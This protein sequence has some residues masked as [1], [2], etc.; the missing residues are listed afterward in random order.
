MTTV[1]E[2]EA[3]AGA[4][5][6]RKSAGPGTRVTLLTGGG[7]KSYA[8]GLTE[9]LAAQGIG[10]DFIGSDDLDCPE[11]RRQPE[12]KFLNFRGDQRK[13]ASFSSKVLRILKLYL[14]L[15]G[16]APRARPRV[17]HILWNNKF[18]VFDR[19]VLT[20]YYRL[21]GKR[22]VFTAHN[23]NAG[24]RD[25]NDSF[26]NRVSLRCQYFLSDR[27]FVH[28]ERMKREMLTEFH[29]PESK[30]IIIPFGINNT[31]PT[32]ALTCAEAR[33]ALGLSDTDKAMLF[34]GRIAPYKGLEFLISALRL[35]VEKDPSYR[36]VIAGTVK[37]CAEY[38]ATIQQTIAE[39]RLHD[40]I[41]QRIEFIPDSKVE[42][43]FKGCDVVV[44]PYT[45]IFQS[46]VLSLGYSFGLPVVATD[47][48]ALKD[49]IVEGKTGF[50][51]EPRNPAALAA[52]ITAYFTSD[53]YRELPR[54]R[55]E[56]CEY[57]NE[58]YSW[59]KV[60][61][62]TSRVYSELVPGDQA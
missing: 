24:K 40:K 55:Q 58:H 8:I 61:E 49:D 18:Q 5:S 31:S 9:A 47:V 32:T 2:R 6:K 3:S 35:L 28:T 62:I 26:L 15:L 57:A 48:G 46:G 34:F 13:E 20:L 21:L 23:V 41:S 29:V 27:I 45:G 25:G 19:T 4:P 12:V 38:W 44:L 59:T 50:I 60:G 39:G 52:A 42:L 36:V 30:V 43:F 7:D 56:I 37:D 33:Q 16:Y 14:R 1:L 54:R 53:L 22:I 17:F 10:L 51:C 11:V